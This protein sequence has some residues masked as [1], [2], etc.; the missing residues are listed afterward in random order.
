MKEWVPIL[1]GRNLSRAEAAIHALAKGLTLSEPR[2]IGLEASY[3]FSLAFGT[4]GLGIFCYYHWLADQDPKLAHAARSFLAGALDALSLQQMPADFFRGFAGI[5]WA[6]EHT[7]DLLWSY[8]ETEESCAEIDVALGHWC[9]IRSTSVELLDGC[10]GVCA[11]ATERSESESAIELRQIVAQRIIDE[12][13]VVPQGTA[14]RIAPRIAGHYQL[15]GYGDSSTLRKL[16]DSG[17]Y[18]VSVA[19]GAAGIVGGLSHLLKGDSRLRPV[20]ES[21]VRWILSTRSIGQIP[22]QFPEMV[23]A[24]LQQLTTGWCN[25]DLGIGVVLFN[26]AQLLED[27]G[28]ERDALDILTTESCKSI[29]QIEEFNRRNY[30][31]CHGSAG[32]AHVFNRLYQQTG[33]SQFLQSAT[34]WI[35]H[36][37]S[38]RLD[39]TGIGGYV[40]DEPNNGGVK[41]PSGL[42]MGAA[43]LGLVLLAAT[44]N[45]EP[46]WDRALLI[47]PP[48][49][50]GRK[51]GS[52][53][54]K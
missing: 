34:Y 15:A 52:S 18:K 25:G 10:A 13:D 48:R 39:G 5:V 22:Q 7:K 41:I 43:G 20:V 32:R 46:L 8:G 35:E 28:L 2:R 42:L 24:D 3:P 19:H 9:R 37:L 40:V 38:L 14:W 6:C 11:Y 49:L 26:I 36:I 51:M 23:G 12:S 17:V 29:D 1:E 50:R 31:L 53:L 27:A 16:F 4:A 33:N 30:N 47:G 45:V 54:G 21:A 44:T